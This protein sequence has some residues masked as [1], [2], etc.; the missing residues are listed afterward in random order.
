MNKV[1]ILINEIKNDE[2]IKRFKL[3]E[4]VIDQDKNINDN[5][6]KLLDLQKIMVNDREKNKENFEVSKKIYETAKTALTSNIVIS[7]YLDLLEEVNYDL[8]MIQSII[9]NE[10]SADFE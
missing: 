10:I 8:Q 5:F 3:L 6:K 9:A 7:E 2:T 1:D 4:N